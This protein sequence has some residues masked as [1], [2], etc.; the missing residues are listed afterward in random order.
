MLSAQYTFTGD[1]NGRYGG[2][3]I[4]HFYDQDYTQIRAGI[5]R[6]AQTYPRPFRAVG[7]N[8]WAYDMFTNKANDSRF[9][10]TY[11]PSYACN[12]ATTAPNMVR[13]SDASAYYYNTYLKD[14]HTDM[15]GGDSARVG[16]SK[17]EYQK[18]SLVFIE[19]SKDEPVDSLW[20]NSQPFYML[21]RWTAGSPNKAGYYDYDAA[22]NITGFKPGAAPD[23]LNP[24]VTDTVNRDL[25][26]RTTV[27]PEDQDRYGCDVYYDAA[28]VY[29]STAK[30]WDVN[31]GGG[32]N[33]RGNG[34]ID[35]PL[36]RLAETYLIR[37]EA[38]GRQNNYTAAMDDINVIRQRAAYHPGE[39]RSDVL[40]TMEPGVL[41]GRLD[42]PADEKVAPYTVNADTYD[43]IRVTGDEWQDGTEKA[44][45][46]NY[47]PTVAS[48]PTS[49]PVLNRFIHFIYNEKA[50][51]FIFEMQITEDL[52]NAGILWDR[53]Y[54]RDYFGAPV[55]STGT[56]DYPFPYDP[57]D[58]AEYGIR[59]AIGTGRGQFDKHH[60][61]KAWPIGYLQLLTDEEG[62][63]LDATAMAAYQNPGY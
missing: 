43:K 37:A 26:Y 14:L 47:P 59:G 41:T 2:S 19:N 62:N 8:D 40:V 38:Y 51:E 44:K 3:Q 17:V 1:Y 52:H 33:D 16:V 15:Y 7:S 45:M 46:E 55:E 61:F 60:T 35:I 34:S 50:R 53:V 54:Y 58:V 4:I 21:A 36:F 6:N 20:I 48:H 56:A 13:W 10:K 57:H 28:M 49:D 5:D 27:D 9:Y 31:R 32:T 12:N 11:I 39:N 25:R 30:Y 29:E 18:R 24:V 63:A 22:G 23:P 42:I